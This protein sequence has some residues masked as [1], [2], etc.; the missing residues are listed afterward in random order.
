MPRNVRIA[1]GMVFALCL[2]A[3]YYFLYTTPALRYHGEI[4]LAPRGDR[5]DTV[6]TAGDSTI[7]VQTTADGTTLTLA[8]PVGTHRFTVTQA[9]D[10]A[11]VTGKDGSTVW[12]D[13][14]ANPL[15]SPD[16]SFVE[17]LGVSRDISE[18]KRYESRLRDAHAARCGV[19]V[20]RGVRDVSRRRV[21]GWSAP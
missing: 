20:R 11:T 5:T 8:L 1:L 21:P 17:V 12:T 15:L 6:Y 7:H 14:S 3:W 16:G 19:G 10:R 2:A 13:V 4:F 18:R 9:G